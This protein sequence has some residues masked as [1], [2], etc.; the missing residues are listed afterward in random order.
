[1]SG[2]P[3]RHFLNEYNNQRHY[4]KK[5][6]KEM[7]IDLDG[8]GTDYIRGYNR[9]QAVPQHTV[10]ETIDSLNAAIDRLDSIIKNMQKDLPY[11][12]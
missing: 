6:S 2:M 10:Q 1:M 4:N 3:R 11:K 9:G 12:E 5:W 7:V 8:V